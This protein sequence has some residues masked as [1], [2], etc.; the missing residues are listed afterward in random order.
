MKR[1]NILKNVSWNYFLRLNTREPL[2]YSSTLVHFTANFQFFVQ[3]Q[4]EKI[5]EIFL[6]TGISKRNLLLEVGNYSI[7]LFAPWEKKQSKRER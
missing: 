5:S 7:I 4:R 3:K 2:S 1:L 6:L